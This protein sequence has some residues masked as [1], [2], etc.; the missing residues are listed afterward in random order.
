MLRS[1]FAVTLTLAA[2]GC[3]PP[4]LEAR[5][6]LPDVVTA[7]QHRDFEL[8]VCRARIAEV[9]AQPTMP[10]TPAF[11][12]KRAAIL[13]RAVGEPTV[14]IR[15]PAPVVDPPK[16]GERAVFRVSRV[17]RFHRFDKPAMRERLLR[18]GYVYSTDPHE[19]FAL[20]RDLRLQDLFDEE[21][22][23]LQR[24]EN[25]YRLHKKRARYETGFEYR[26]AEGSRTGWTAKILFGDRVARTLAELA[27]PLHRD[28]RALRV[29]EGFERIRITHRTDDALLADLRYGGKWYSALISADGARLE[30]ACLDAPREA[31]EVVA[32]LKRRTARRRRAVA[33][34]W[35]SADALVA[36]RLPFDRPRNA[37]DH[38]SDGQL[39]AQWEWAYERGWFS[40]THEDEGYAVF[41]RSGKPY[42]PQTCVEMVLD[43]FERASGNWFQKQGETRAR[44]EG[45]LDFSDFG[46]V[47]RNGVLAFEKFAK[48]TP[49]LF[50][51]R[52]IPNDDRV[53]FRDRDAFFAYLV[54]HADAFEPGDIVAIQ[55]PKRD[56]HIHQHAILVRDTDPVTGMPYGLTDQ[57]KR[58]RHRSWEGIMA[59]AP[60]RAL[61]YHIKPTE[62]LM[63]K[64]D[65]G[66]GK[67]DR[68]AGLRS[69]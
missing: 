59:E 37:E 62:K 15:E 19:A 18:E 68:L 10:G 47:Q 44:T 12:E 14:F 3:E 27:T 53:P 8:E 46:I 39:R 41:D 63:A 32:Q 22:I 30:L 48:K 31:R 34:L 17:K 66:E 43:T 6:G 13:G 2:I 50:T 58:P 60:L 56:G 57:M 29:R 51:H 33:A 49:E 65:P 52:R 9:K 40:F 64:L 5:G 69:Q 45:G 61:L 1:F 26:Y 38:F 35:N 25:V 55:G 23:F 7:A 16:E 36:D 20:V 42:P 28:V 24:G 21:E 54:K 11:D 67:L 4:P